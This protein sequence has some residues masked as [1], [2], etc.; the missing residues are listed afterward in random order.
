MALSPPG[1][2]LGHT[3]AAATQASIVTL[4]RARIAPARFL[5]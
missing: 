4:T 1:N 2:N 3:V 5:R